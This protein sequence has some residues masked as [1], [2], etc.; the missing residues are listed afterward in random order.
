MMCIAIPGKVIELE[1]MMAIVD[2]GGVSQRVNIDLIDYVKL[3]DYLLIHCGC[4]IEKLNQKAAQETKRLLEQ[5]RVNNV[6][7]EKNNGLL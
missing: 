6:D 7:G 3:G 4:A 5:G 1:E 2:F